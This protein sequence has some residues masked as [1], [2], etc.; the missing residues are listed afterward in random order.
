MKNSSLLKKLSG[1]SL[2]YG[3]SSVMIK[4][5]SFILFPFFA[6]KFSPEDYGVV[7]ILNT[8]TF[9]TNAVIVLGLDA[10]VSRWFYDDT[11]L[12]HRKK[13][14]SNWFFTHIGNAII[15]A[16]IILLVGQFYF[17]DRFIPVQ[18][19]RLL[20][21]IVVV[22]IIMYVPPAVTN[23]FFVQSKK[24]IP[25]AVFSLL[26]SLF[27]A[28]FSLYFVFK[29]NMGLIGFYLGQTVAFSLYTLFGSILY[30]RKLI[31]YKFFDLAELKKMIRYGINV[32]PANV[33]GQLLLFLSALIIQSFASSKGLGYYQIAVMLASGILLV[34]WPFTLAFQPLSFSIM[35]EPY[36]NQ[37][38]SFIL[39]VYV[40]L[41]CGL[42]LLLSLFYP[43]IIHVLVTDK[44]ADS[45][46]IAGILTFGNFIYSLNTI[47]ALG[48]SKVKKLKHFG[49]VVSISNIITIGAI[50]IM[51]KYFQLNGAAFA[52]ISG[53]TLITAGIFYYSQ[54]EYH[55]PYDLLKVSIL[56]LIAFGLFI[57]NNFILYDYPHTF[58]IKIGLLLVFS[59]LVFAL[60]P[61]L[62]RRFRTFKNRLGFSS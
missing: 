16:I 38:F 8:L 52:L 17:L 32:I 15:A 53:Q 37:F 28:L 26:S 10:A 30:L 44:Y 46:A 41:G 42:C 21:L 35:N 54:K 60:F 20:L 40:I 47:A 11:G 62:L 7:N 12:A 9:F 57:L 14:Y 55:I 13:I 2:I 48:M 19:D 24:P 27:S 34:T 39:K 6:R 18:N 1:D 43:E 58:L 56:I 31:S 23:S 5:I 29:L 3:F 59:I 45:A 61:S 50:Y 33:S 51:S 36:S 25:S 4:F 49:R 22:N